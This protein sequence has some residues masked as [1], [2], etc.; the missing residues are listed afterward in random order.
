MEQGVVPAETELPLQL[1]RKLAGTDGSGVH[2]TRR[3][4]NSLGLKTSICL[5][6]WKSY[7]V[8]SLCNSCLERCFVF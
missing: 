6:K 3:S 4:D 7:L 1:Q 8:M 2:S 5:D